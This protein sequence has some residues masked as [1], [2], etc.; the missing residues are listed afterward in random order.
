VDPRIDERP[1]MEAVI[2]G[3][4]VDPH[5]VRADLLTPLTGLQRMLWH[6]EGAPSAA[7][8]YMD[9]AIFEKAQQAGIRV[10]FSGYDGDSTV[11]YGF[12]YLEELARTGRWLAL[13]KEA[14]AYAE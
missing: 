3:G 4:G 7:N 9:W 1:Y 8:L 2:A 6:E 12:E 5:W 13:R 11:S 14:A 10:L